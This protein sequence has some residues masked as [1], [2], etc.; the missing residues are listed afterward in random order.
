VA[1]IDLIE[2][3][4]ESG[5]EM[6]HRVPEYGSGEFVL[7]S[8]LV[9]RESQ[10]AIFFRDGKA[11][12]VFTA[13]RHTLSTMNIPILSGLFG[14]PFGGKSPFRA[15]VYFVSMREFIDMKWGTPQPILFRDTDLG[16]VRLRA[17]GTYSMQIA[18][19]Q[20]FVNKI[21]GQQG[22]YDTGQIQ[23]YLR[24]SIVQ[25]LTT[26]LGQMMQSIL[27]LPAQYNNIAS[28]T[29]ASV[30]QEFTTLGLQLRGFNLTA[31]TPPEEVQKYIDQRSSMGAIGNM[32]QYMQFQTAQALRDAANNPGGAGD[33]QGAG[34]GAGMGMG[35]GMAMMDQMRQ[36][37]QGGQGQ[38]V[39]QQGGPAP[40]QGYAPQQG[41][42][43]PQQG[44]GAA[45]ASG[46]KFCPEC[47]QPVTP[48]SKF[49]GNCGHRLIP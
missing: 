9:V 39:P 34:L 22:V 40:Q 20:L 5:Q 36:A 15:E 13:G 30:L 25:N 47:G 17:F 2:F 11:L 24:N 18:D 42:Q 49:C 16:M 32:N 19:P 46:P 23:D 45:P 12:D 8:Q 37:M 29:R 10:N 26:I 14:I 1:I 7:G 44:Q 38:P 48:G 31:V 41:G 3:P 33:A 21:V 35:M 43:M 27:D 4:D 6:V 28:A